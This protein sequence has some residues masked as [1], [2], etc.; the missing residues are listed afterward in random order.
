MNIH[1]STLK[2]SVSRKETLANY[3]FQNVG[4]WKGNCS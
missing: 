2:V 1:I 4:H 3:D